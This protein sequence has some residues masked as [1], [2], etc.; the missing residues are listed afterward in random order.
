[1]EPALVAQALCACVI[2]GEM[3]LLRRFLLAKANPNSVLYSKTP[4]L[5][6]AAGVGSL[7]A[8]K[9]L[10][11]GGGADVTLTT[12]NGYTAYDEAVRAHARPVME[13]LQPLMPAHLIRHGPSL[14]NVP[15][16]QL[17]SNDSVG[18]PSP[19]KYHPNGMPSMPDHQLVS[20]DSLVMPSPG[21]Y[22]P[23]G[24]PSL[25]SVSQA[26]KNSAT[27]SGN[28]S[29]AMADEEIRYAQQS[30]DDDDDLPASSPPHDYR[31]A[32]SA[33]H[34]TQ[35][36]RVVGN[37]EK[38][39]KELRMESSVRVNNSRRNSTISGQMR[40]SVSSQPGDADNQYANP[41][42]T[43]PPAPVV[44]RGRQ[45]R[46]S[47]VMQMVQMA[48]AS[49]GMAQGSVPDAA[50]RNSDSSGDEQ[51]FGAQPGLAAQALAAVPPVSGFASPAGMA[52]G[53]G[54]GGEG[55]AAAGSSAGGGGGS[56]GGG[57]GR[58]GSP[59]IPMLRLAPRP[60]SRPELTPRPESRGS[61]GTNGSEISGS[62]GA[63]DFDS[64]ADGGGVGMRRAEAASHLAPPLSR[65]GSVRS[66]S[67][68]GDAEASVPSRRMMS[69]RRAPSQ[70]NQQQP[71][72]TPRSSQANQQP[73]DSHRLDATDSLLTTRDVDLGLGTYLEAA[74]RE[75]T[76][77]VALPA[78]T[79]TIVALPAVT[80]TTRASPSATSGAPPLA[81]STTGASPAATSTPGAS[82]AST[83]TTRASPASTSTP[84]ASPASTSTTRASPASTSTPGA[85]PASTS[86]T[87][88]SP[89]LTSTRAPLAAT[90]TT[91]ASPSVTSGASP[92][93]T[94]MSAA[95]LIPSLEEE[96]SLTALLSATQSQGG[97]DAG[98]AG[99]G[100]TTLGNL[101]ALSRDLADSS[102]WPA[103][104]K[105]TPP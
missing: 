51:R 45:R 14:T 74:R 1:M 64:A 31:S 67:N 101:D 59:V 35:M 6:I 93:A 53:R 9:L 47:I 10:V 60:E 90:S 85:S 80:S 78:G 42:G 18:M 12:L 49:M 28:H 61:T 72:G 32:G 33:T 63:N 48:M 55:A 66:V 36:V 79:S 95:Q 71:V 97:A 17:V 19:G 41:A 5:H 58:G 68:L 100:L 27:T 2:D 3:P 54:G 105:Q 15:D 38:S 16:H 91:E 84:G 96:D 89:A 21:Q 88:A 77:T 70:T 92:S 83:S 23:N 62:S 75:S 20:E 34:P 69:G 102:P 94:S 104:R 40:M 98:A 87:R 30:Y 11:E 13:Y 99:G 43:L 44:G 7:K 37:K 25:V 39:V 50:A 81:A 22:H 46:A 86:T 8:V 29:L 57:I 26:L 52:G 76:T 73:M 65:E 24:M 56:G 103:D 4:A 82:P